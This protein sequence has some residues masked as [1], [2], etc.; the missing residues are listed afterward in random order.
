VWFPVILACSR[1]G[2]RSLASSSV[3]DGSGWVQIVVGFFGRRAKRRVGP[4]SEIRDA[5]SGARTGFQD[6][7]AHGGQC[8]DYFTTKWDQTITDLS[9]RPTDKHLRASLEDAAKQWTEVFA[10]APGVRHPRV[11]DLNRPFDPVYAAEDASD[12]QMIER[13][14]AA[15]HKG[16]ECVETALDR[17]VKLE[18]KA[19]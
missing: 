8:T 18:R 17:L 13:Q 6:V 4:A 14:I 16:I 15:A 7:T 5:L 11:H 9:K 2:C 12:R 10:N 1:A 19:I 3:A